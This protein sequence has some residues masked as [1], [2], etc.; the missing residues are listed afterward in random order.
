M[1]VPAP[2]REVNHLAASSTVQGM[3]EYANRICAADELDMRE[4]AMGR[5]IADCL[6]SP[7]LADW[8]KRKAEEHYHA[9][10][11][12]DPEYARYQLAR[13]DIA[14]LIPLMRLPGHMGW[15]VAAR[16]AEFA[17]KE[18]DIDLLERAVDRLR[19]ST[20]VNIE[21]VDPQLEYVL[22]DAALYY[23]IKGQYQEARLKAA[24]MRAKPIFRQRA[25][26]DLCR[27]YLGI[28]FGEAA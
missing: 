26:L 10:N 11:A 1:A 12:S 18:P 21:M 9:G 22:A 15:H 2:A 19:D 20:G 3:I 5:Q 13:M 7:D 4:L 6:G 27:M 23:R 28:H 17:F 14:E 8:C 24:L 16:L 25:A